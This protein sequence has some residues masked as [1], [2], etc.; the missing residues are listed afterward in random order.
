MNHRSGRAGVV[1]AILV[2]GGLTLAGSWSLESALAD[3]KVEPPSRNSPDEPIAA[4]PSLVRAAEFLDAVALDWTRTRKCG[5]CHTNYAYLLARPALREIE[6]PAMAEI[7]SFFE[8]RVSHWDDAKPSS[9][10]RWDTEVVATASAL[11]LN[12]AATTGT[13]HPTTRAALDRMWTLQRPDGTWDWLK[14]DWPPYEYDDYYGALFAALGV[15]AA[16]DGYA[17]A[18]SAREGIE[19]LRG[20]F[21]AN[22]P[23]NLHHAT[24]QLW[25]SQKLEGLMTRA[26]TERTV[27]R[28]LALQRP[29]G[30]WS[31]PSL[32]EWDRHDGTRNDGNAPSDGY[33]TGLVVFVLRQTGLSAQ[34]EPIRRGVTWLRTHQRAS[35]RWFTRSLST[36]KF[37]YIANAG[38]GFAVLA[39]KACDPTAVS[40]EKGRPE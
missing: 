28:L 8:E 17:Q 23:P 2:L 34:E 38:T 24:F 20:F 22:E 13:L 14:C 10:P 37:H 31:L 40:R 3:L 29:D 33:A 32:G 35:G 7:R 4:S 9:R 27:E 18:E 19:R 26:Q 6:G 12:D 15:G 21:R 11:A 16:P 1:G 5:T 25:A 39:L 36:D 30:G